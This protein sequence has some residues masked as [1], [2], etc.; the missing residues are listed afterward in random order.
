M[1]KPTRL[2]RSRGMSPISPAA[3]IRLTND[4]DACSSGVRAREHR[5]VRSLQRVAYKQSRQRLA[6]IT[7]QPPT[8]EPRRP[9]FRFTV[10]WGN[11]GES[12]GSG[13]RCGTRGSRLPH[14]GIAGQHGRINAG[15]GLNLGIEVI[16]PPRVLAAVRNGIV[17]VP[18]KRICKARADRLELIWRAVSSGEGNGPMERGD[19]GVSAWDLG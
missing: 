5:R 3:R 10:A 17:S 19:A 11:R 6:G 15:I 2:R 4:G 14:V 7:G 1:T 18:H 9:L 16:S 13:R 12:G 8:P